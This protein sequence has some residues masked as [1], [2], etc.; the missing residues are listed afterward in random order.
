MANVSWTHLPH[1]V[2]TY[3]PDEIAA[4]AGG[5]MNVVAGVE[6]VGER[7][8][9]VVERAAIEARPIP[10]DRRI[11]DPTDGEANAVSRRHRRARYDRK[12]PM[13]ARYLAES[14]VTPW[15]YWKRA[16]LNMSA[17]A[18][19]RRHRAGKKFPGGEGATP[20]RA[21]KVPPPP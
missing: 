2:S 13:S 15:S 11:R 8:Q 19:P 4:I 6:I 21:A 10:C 18:A 1:Q 7:I 14:A 3:Q 12:I 16:A 20:S 17:A 9:R 5:S